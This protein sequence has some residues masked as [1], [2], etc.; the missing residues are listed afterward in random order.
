M[1][2][3]TVSE[4]L[5]TTRALQI[6]P[7]ACLHYIFLPSHYRD[8]GTCK[9]DDPGASVMREWGYKWSVKKKLWIA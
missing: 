9:C 7:R 6:N 5:V 1:A 2:K 8:D 4:R 3:V